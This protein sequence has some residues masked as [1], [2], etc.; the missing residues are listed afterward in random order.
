VAPAGRPANQVCF[1]E[2]PKVLGHRRSAHREQRGELVGGCRAHREPL[3]DR[4]PSA[5]RHRSERRIEAVMVHVN[6]DSVSSSLRV[7]NASD[8][9]NPSGLRWS[10][11]SHWQVIDV[12]G[13]GRM[14]FCSSGALVDVSLVV[15]HMIDV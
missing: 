5:V 7:P 11:R 4:A 12:S 13:A 8:S 3:D 10:C 6:D 2:H 9:A 14:S 15:L 1:A